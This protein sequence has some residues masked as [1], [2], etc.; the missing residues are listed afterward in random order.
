MYNF[1]FS[2]LKESNT[3]IKVDDLIRVQDEKG[4]EKA[5][6][7]LNLQGTAYLEFSENGIFLHSEEYIE[8]LP[9]KRDQKE[10]ATLIKGASNLMSADLSTQTFLM[11]EVRTL[12]AIVE[13]NE[14]N[15]ERLHLYISD[16]IEDGLSRN[17]YL[18]PQENWDK[19]IDEEISAVKNEIV[20]DFGT[21]YL[22]KDNSIRT[23]I[24]AK[25][26]EEKKTL[27]QKNKYI[28]ELENLKND[29]SKIDDFIY[30]K[31]ENDFAKDIYASSDPREY[32]TWKTQE[33]KERADSLGL[34][35]SQ[36]KCIEEANYKVDKVRN[37][38]L[39]ATKTTTEKIS[40]VDKMVDFG[41]QIKDEEDRQTIFDNAKI[42]LTSRIKGWKEKLHEIKESTKEKW[43]KYG[44]KVIGAAAIAMTLTGIT[45]AT[46]KIKD[47]IEI[48]DGI[49][50]APEL[51]DGEDPFRDWG[52][53]IILT[54]NVG[55]KGDLSKEASEE[56]ARISLQAEN[57][58]ATKLAE[59]AD[60]ERVEVTEDQEADRYVDTEKTSNP[61]G[62]IVFTVESEDGK[63]EV[64]TIDTENKELTV[65]GGPT[66]DVS[67][68]E[69]P[70]E[71]NIKVENP[72]PADTTIKNE[73]LTVV[74]QNQNPGDG[75]QD[76][77]DLG[78]APPPEKE[79]LENPNKDVL[80]PSTEEVQGQDVV[81]TE[82]NSLAEEQE[83]TK[84][85][86]K[87]EEIKDETNKIYEE[88]LKEEQNEEHDISNRPVAPRG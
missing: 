48:Q 24:E 68:F 59:M 49:Q 11:D 12:E 20:L 38:F 40:V 13:D 35:F 86:E 61:D 69:N 29:H 80:E 73:E 14:V 21:R 4:T 54:D 10:L 33:L 15:Q 9:I 51:D 30:N 55:E 3:Q 36:T 85:D 23:V 39:K 87:A 75:L 37:A 52:D 7:P 78:I 28:E 56:V 1:L 46:A 18:A 26:D 34:T 71:I 88:K 44:F 58:G 17:L 84:V 76:I 81:N 47:E 43:E 83:Q 5:L 50:R 2:T 72:T 41:K 65:E 64:A 45:S 32:I 53:P 31:I 42:L 79:V 67:G 60:N 22:E 8:G 62:T 25:T 77:S 82:E 19:I 63:K 74:D 16:F 66:Y 57:N 6:I 27:R 70:E